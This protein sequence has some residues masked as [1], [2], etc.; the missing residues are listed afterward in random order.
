MAD[1]IAPT[2]NQIAA[3][4]GNDPEAIRAIERLFKVAGQLTPADIVVLTQLITDNILATGAADN[5]AEVALSV[6]T[7]AA[8]LAGLSM[9]AEAKAEAAMAV[10]TDAAQIAGLSMFAEAKAEAAMAVAADAES[11]ASLAA[12]QPAPIPPSGASGSF[13]AGIQVVTVRNGIVI[14]IV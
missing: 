9:F 14:S 1:P 4:V 7:D 2:R 12:T 5:K 3:F 6:A 11:M 8:Q 10:A 13:L